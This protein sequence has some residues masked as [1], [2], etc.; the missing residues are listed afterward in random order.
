MKHI[1][2][3]SVNHAQRNR[4]MKKIF[5]YF[6]LM[7]ACSAG[8]A[9]TNF[10]PGDVLMVGLST[11]NGGGTKNQDIVIIC[12]KDVTP[13]TYFDFTDNGFE[14]QFA[15]EWGT[16]EGFFRVTR[17]AGAS[18]IP[19]GTPINVQI[20]NNLVDYKVNICGVNDN[21]NWTFNDFG[22]QSANFNMEPQDNL[23][24]LSGG[25][26]DVSAGTN[27][28]IYSNGVALYG[29]I[30]SNWSASPGYNTNAGSTI[31]QNVDCLSINFSL[32]NNSARRVKYRLGPFTPANQE[33]WINRI[34]NSANWQ[35][36]GNISNYNSFRN[37]TTNMCNN[38]K[39][40]VLPTDTTVQE[41]YGTWRGTAN[42]DWFN[43]A[44]WSGKRV[45]DTTITVLI[46]ENATTRAVISGAS[47][48]AAK[49]GNKAG[50]LDLRL[51]SNTN[52]LQIKY[53]AAGTSEL[54]V[55]GDIYFEATD[56][57]GH[58][59]GGRLDMNDSV[60]GTP[61]GTIYLHGNWVNTLGT[62][63]FNEGESTVILKGGSPSVI[64][65]VGAGNTETFHN[66]R[67]IKTNDVTLNSNIEVVNVLELSGNYINT[68]SNELR[69]GVSNANKGTLTYNS[70]A[71]KG[72]MRRWFNG[73][74]SG[75]A[76]SLFPIASADDNRKFVRVSY[77]TAPST[78]GH[79]TASFTTNNPGV[80]G[81]PIVTAN[82]GGFP[83]DVLNVNPGGYWIMDNQID[84]LND[85]TY[86]I[87]CTAEGFNG[88]LDI[89]ELTL[90]KRVGSNPWTTPGAHQ[91]T[92]GSM[93][94]PVVMRTG[95]SG[96]SNFSIGQNS[97]GALPV[98]LVSF[99][100]TKAN[101]QVYLNWSTATEINSS[102]YEIERSTD[103]VTFEKIGFETA[104]FNSVE[105]INYQFIDNQPNNGINYYRLKMVDADETFEY[106]PVRVVNV[107]SA[108]PAV[109]VN[110]YPNPAANFI[111]VG[112]TLPATEPTNVYVRNM[113]G[114]VVYEG[115]IETGSMV[116]VVDVNMLPLGNYIATIKNND[117]LS[118]VRFAKTN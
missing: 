49:F 78:G 115:I 112:L 103:G 28:G 117:Q 36:L 7:M 22:G 10:T 98:T 87:S 85:G 30:S 95:V 77:T 97:G 71:I 69:L 61:D 110:I 92:T 15:G 34:S 19:A 65:T 41:V 84:A 108:Q 8:I 18:V 50:C 63:Q 93:A 102:H 67:N 80:S 57:T 59:P 29:F 35:D 73:T 39:F 118:T 3:N 113:N 55:K 72:N 106:S 45:P 79:L 4:F 99:T 5:T 11:N 76:T 107:S 24:I 43:C 96:W 2:M 21:A 54:T 13:G 26:W 31:F 32:G 14:R 75:D 94:M 51:K 64:S 100:A 111:S 44:N 20:I 53:S 90:L 88:F 86:T 27:R 58:Q 47:S 42:T 46:P 74:N 1:Y 48:N 62:A 101:E 52:S 109:T 9:Q 37:Y 17:N 81:L 6:L 114:R 83:F 23:W 12:L 56:L 16:A 68:G 70:G 25:T 116:K 91:P 82:T 104:A 33:G 40:D 38:I 89:E 60:S 66:L 105:L